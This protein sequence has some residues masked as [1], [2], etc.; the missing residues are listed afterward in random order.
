MDASNVFKNMLRNIEDSKLNY[1]MS[2]TPFSASISLKCSF[3]K[4]FGDASNKT[5]VESLEK[6]SRKDFQLGDTK[7]RELEEENIKLQDEITKLKI[8]FEN[9]KKRTVE[10][11]TETL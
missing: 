10:E 4:R 2:R 1:S 7:V 3:A 6:L 11:V 5:D 8:T 9:E